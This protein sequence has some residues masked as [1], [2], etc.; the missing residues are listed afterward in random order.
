M[1]LGKV[2]HLDTQSLWL[3]QAVRQK[4]VGMA[5]VAGTMNPADAMTKALDSITMDRLLGLMALDCRGGGAAIAPNAEKLDENPERDVCSA[6]V[7][8]A[9]GQKVETADAE[10]LAGGKDDE[11]NEEKEEKGEGEGKDR[12]GD[13]LPDGKK[14]ERCEHG[15]SAGDQAA[16]IA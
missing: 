13:D 5:K 16:G 8:R 4:R 9:D 6:G 12:E 15:E 1:G 7:L 10:G 11:P 2:R 14:K 3:Q